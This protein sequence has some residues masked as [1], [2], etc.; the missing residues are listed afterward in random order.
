[1]DKGKKYERAKKRV[2]ALKAFY[3][4]LTVYLTVNIVLFILNM[5]TNPNDLWFV[6]PLLGWGIGL[7]IHFVVLILGGKWGS[8]WEDKKIKELMEKEDL[9]NDLP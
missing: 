8:K 1:M 3:I 7:T 6:L 2:E 5:L 9:N 4:H